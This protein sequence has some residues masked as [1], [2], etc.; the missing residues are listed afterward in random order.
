MAKNLPQME[1]AR[2]FAAYVKVNPNFY[3]MTGDEF[4]MCKYDP[5][6]KKQSKA[7]CKVTHPGLS[8][9][10]EGQNKQV[11]SHDIAQCVLRL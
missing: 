5:E 10:Q 11:K 9:F 4:W 3:V 8:W 6:T 2:N 1:H 7:K